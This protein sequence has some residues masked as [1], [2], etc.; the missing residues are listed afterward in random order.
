MRS[1][2]SGSLCDVE[3]LWDP[4]S[5]QVWLLTDNFLVGNSE[6]SEGTGGSAWGEEMVASEMLFLTASMR[7][8][9]KFAKQK[10]RAFQIKHN[11][12]L[13]KGIINHVIYKVYKG[14]RAQSN[15]FGPIAAGRHRKKYNNNKL[16]IVHNYF[17][18]FCFSLSYVL[19]L[20][21]NI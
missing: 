19:W 14:S 2:S 1:E 4:K 16:I 18:F 12:S 7:E 11:E 20:T 15:F 5:W 6:V 21:A 17:H 9:R 13:F 10:L 3:L 8:P